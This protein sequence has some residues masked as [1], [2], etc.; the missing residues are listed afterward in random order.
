MQERL[1]RALEGFDTTEKEVKLGLA[2]DGTRLLITVADNGPG[3]RPDIVP[4]LT[5]RGATFKT[6]GT[7][8]GLS[9]ARK[10]AE[11]AG[12]KLDIQSQ[13]GLGALVT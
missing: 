6:D 3:I 4:Q 9:H 12:G 11:D 5:K 1:R 7:G 10:V 8:I 2:L 13:V